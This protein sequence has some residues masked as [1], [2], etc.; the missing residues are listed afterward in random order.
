MNRC[1]TDDFKSSETVSPGSAIP[2][3]ALL[4]R[5]SLSSFVEGAADVWGVGVGEVGRGDFEHQLP[6][7][8]RAGG[9]VVDDAA[10]RGDSRVRRRIGGWWGR[11]VRTSRTAWRTTARTVGSSRAFRP[12]WASAVS[13]R[14]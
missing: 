3:R 2:G 6:D 11:G 7:R 14:V 5:N 8:A 13:R 4:I 9:E 10:Q 1:G 12:L